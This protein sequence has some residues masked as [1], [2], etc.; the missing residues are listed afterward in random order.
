MGEVKECQ[1]LEAEIGRA[2]L[3]VRRLGYPV[4]L[5]EVINYLVEERRR[6]MDKVRRGFLTR[7][8]NLLME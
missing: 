1:Y 8:I 6:E 4:T 5:G 3:Q 2:V 7:A